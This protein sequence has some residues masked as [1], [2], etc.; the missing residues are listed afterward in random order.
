[1]A[2][3]ESIE[4]NYMTQSTAIRLRGELAKAEKATETQ[5]QIYATFNLFSDN[6]AKK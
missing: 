1:M 3:A 6:R 4:P 2:S 5:R